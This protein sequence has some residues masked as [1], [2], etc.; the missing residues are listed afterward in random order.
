MLSFGLTSSKLLAPAGPLK[1]KKIFF[2]LSFLLNPWFFPAPP[3]KEWEKGGWARGVGSLVVQP[4]PILK[5]TLVLCSS[6]RS[7]I[8]GSLLVIVVS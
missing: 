8:G 5:N 6:R 2:F 7:W 4:P 1:K 3:R